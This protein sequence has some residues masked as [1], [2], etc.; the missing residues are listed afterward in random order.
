[1]A[2]WALAGCGF[3]S[4]GRGPT[5]RLP[6]PTTSPTTLS[7]ESSPVGPILTT[8]SGHTLYDFAPDT[9]THSACVSSIC[10]FLWPPIDASGSTTVSSALHQDLVGSIER[11]GGVQVTYGGHPLYTY[12]ADTKPGMVLGQAI[13]QAG[14]RWYV[15]RPDGQQVTTPFTVGGNRI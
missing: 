1:V 8:G 15:I 13:N 11:P 9:P 7:T 2:G 12:N 5:Y 3:L 4:A 10:V 14:G 6:T